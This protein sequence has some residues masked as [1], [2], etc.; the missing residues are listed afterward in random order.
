[1]AANE[2][3]NKFSNTVKQKLYEANRL[4]NDLYDLIFSG[5][6]FNFLHLPTGHYGKFLI[7]KLNGDPT[8]IVRPDFS[9]PF[10]SVVLLSAPYA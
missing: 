1:M 10:R 4:N 7:S 5:F 6:K 8:F 2:C 3:S 9:F